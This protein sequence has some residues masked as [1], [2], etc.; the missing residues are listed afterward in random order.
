M[1]LTIKPR[2]LGFFAEF[3][4]CWYRRVRSRNRAV[5]TDCVISYAM[6]SPPVAYFT[7]ACE[8]AAICI[9]RPIFLFAS[10]MRRL[11]SRNRFVSAS[12]LRLSR[13]CPTI[14]SQVSGRERESER[15]RERDKEWDRYRSRPP[16]ASTSSGP[17]TA[18]SRIRH[19]D[20]RCAASV[21]LALLLSLLPSPQAG[22]KRCALHHGNCEGNESE[23]KENYVNRILPLNSQI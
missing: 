22:P 1:C 16:S 15:E 19:R 17:A 14:P 7:S 6:L 20:C 10:S 4:S 3:P 9:T 23:R 21:P 12:D 13:E 18:R 8:K 5:R 2:M 11:M